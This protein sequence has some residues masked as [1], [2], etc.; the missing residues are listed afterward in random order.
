[1][2]T[3]TVLAYV[4][5]NLKRFSQKNYVKSYLTSLRVVCTHVI[6]IFMVNIT[7]WPSIHHKL[8]VSGVQRTLFFC[9][10]F[11]FSLFKTTEICFESTKMEPLK[12]V[13]SLPKWDFF[14]GKKHFTTGKKFRKTDFAPS[15]K[16]S[17]YAPVACKADIRTKYPKQGKRSGFLLFIGGDSKVTIFYK[18]K[19]W[20]LLFLFCV[21]F[22]FFFFL[23]CIIFCSR[24]YRPFVVEGRIWHKN[25]E[26]FLFFFKSLTKL[27]KVGTVICTKHP[28]EECLMYVYRGNLKGE[29]VVV[30]I[31]PSRIW[32]WVIV[33]PDFFVTKPAK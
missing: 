33:P 18:K 7:M 23:N 15:E 8:P 20:F 26:F 10:C 3:P 19:C 16:Y 28:C 27:D 9:F 22:C 5:E 24:L 2:H 6:A 11:F 17:S 25:C 12:F 30:A 31:L 14:T 1:M 13:L 32:R 4:S 21:C 29:S